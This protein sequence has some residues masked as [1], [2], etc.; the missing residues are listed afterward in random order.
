MPLAPDTASQET[1]RLMKGIGPAC[2]D[3]PRAITEVVMATSTLSSVTLSLSDRITAG[4]L[5]LLVG[6]FLV[7]G[8]GLANSATIHD[9]AHDVRHSFGFPCH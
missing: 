4:F 1:C 2:G 9:T 7:F 5:A 6:G 3:I 8:T